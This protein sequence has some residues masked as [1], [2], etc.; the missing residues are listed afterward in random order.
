MGLYS[1]F[2][3]E[4]VKFM[5]LF[6]VPPLSLNFLNDNI[7]RVIVPLITLQ[8]YNYTFISKKIPWCHTILQHHIFFFCLETQVD[9]MMII[10]VSYLK[11]ILDNVF[12]KYNKNIILNFIIKKNKYK[13]TLDE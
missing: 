6:S 9:Q 8:I 11:R 1:A 13:K 2:F 12:K 4:H 7:G 5:T 3:R 10:K